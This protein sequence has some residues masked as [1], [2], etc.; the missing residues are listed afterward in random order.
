MRHAGARVHLALPDVGRVATLAASSGL[1][2]GDAGLE[3]VLRLGADTGWQRRSPLQ[4]NYSEP[5]TAT[6]RRPSTTSPFDRRGRPTCNPKD[7]AAPAWRRLASTI[8]K[9]QRFS[10]RP[11]RLRD[12]AS[13]LPPIGTRCESL[14]TA[15]AV[16]VAVRD[17]KEEP[18]EPGRP[19]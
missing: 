4:R 1:G 11:V 14:I 9:T 10:A 16:S 15:V 18:P 12:G 5:G 17:A 3:V 13:G 2:S 8:E 6:E 7:A 19:L